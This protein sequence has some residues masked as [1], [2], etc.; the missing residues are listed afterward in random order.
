VTV[1]SVKV[2]RYLTPVAARAV[3][4]RDQPRVQLVF[5]RPLQTPLQ[6]AFDA[7][8]VR[9][10]LEERAFPGDHPPSRNPLAWGA[11]FAEIPPIL[12]ARLR[13][14]QAPC[15]DVDGGGD[16][17]QSDHSTGCVSR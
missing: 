12:V 7:G 4:M 2:S 11:K 1:Y 6:A 16:S 17:S 14:S 8:W 9:D 15:A 5:H 13:S 3:A 10:G